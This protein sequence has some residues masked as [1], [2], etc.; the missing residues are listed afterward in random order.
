MGNTEEEIHM[1]MF[2]DVLLICINSTAL[3]YTSH[4]AGI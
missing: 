1:Y 3:P 2:V 4:R